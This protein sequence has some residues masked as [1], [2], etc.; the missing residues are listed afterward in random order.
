M[1]SERDG[2]SSC[3]TYMCLFKGEA[4]SA[5]PDH[6][7]IKYF[8]HKQGILILTYGSIVGGQDEQTLIHWVG[9]QFQKISFKKAIGR[10][11]NISTEMT[12]LKLIYQGWYDT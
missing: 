5:T 8:N 11:V 4:C 1:F 3:I 12:A 10:K 6:R 9:F 7:N 2:I